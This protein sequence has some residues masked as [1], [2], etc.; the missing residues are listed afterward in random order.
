MKKIFTRSDGFNE[1]DLL[2]FGYGHIEAAIALFNDDPLF[3][4]SAG[5]LAHL[6][7]EV[8]LKACHLNVFDQFQETH[9]L[10]ALFDE[11]KTHDSAF[12]I[13]PENF[14]FLKKIDK[15]YLLRYPR[16]KEGP[17]E[18]GSDMLSQFKGLLESLWQVF[19]EKIIEIYSR[20]DPTKKAGRV[21]MEKNM[22]YVPYNL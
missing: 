12:D 8:V 13:E 1:E 17:I 15:L 5:Y 9:N 10:I 2:H 4:D 16:K 22:R 3:L 7:T 18:V 6:G 20:I 19:P 14:D 21:L 11:L